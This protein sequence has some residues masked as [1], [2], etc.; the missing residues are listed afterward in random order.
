MPGELSWEAGQRLR[1]SRGRFGPLPMAFPP[2]HVTCLCSVCSVLLR[3]RLVSRALIQTFLPWLHSPLPNLQ[4]TALA[5]FAEVRRRVGRGGLRGL[6]G[7][8]C[9]LGCL[10]MEETSRGPM[11]ALTDLWLSCS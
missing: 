11:P 5:F 10:F 6:F 7:R 3:A 2:D 1:R 9:C 8:N 4:V